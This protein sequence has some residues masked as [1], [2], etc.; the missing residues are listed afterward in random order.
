MSGDVH[1]ELS[2][3]QVI[4]MRW[5]L[6]GMCRVGRR[7]RARKN[8]GMTLAE[9]TTNEGTHR[10]DGSEQ[11]HIAVI[12]DTAGNGDAA[13]HLCQNIIEK[14][15]SEFLFN[16]TLCQVDAFEAGFVAAP[17]TRRAAEATVVVIATDQSLPDRL[18]EWLDGW[19]AAR[20]VS[21]SALVLMGNK[22][23]VADVNGRFARRLCETYAIDLITADRAGTQRLV[24]HF[25]TQTH[26][27]KNAQ[28]RTSAQ[29][30]LGGREKI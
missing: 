26:E 2:L 16:V 10:T 27:D 30:C 21:E 7:P 28:S 22:G 11:F 29:A 14:F 5:Q 23:T 18:C 9:F 4:V 13:M 25:P 20:P 19:A 8:S 24:D 15:G 3:V 1:P 17:A 12:H 6:C